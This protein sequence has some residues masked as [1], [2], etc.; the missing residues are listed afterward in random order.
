MAKVTFFGGA[1]EVTGSCFLFQSPRFIDSRSGESFPFDPK[2]I[3][4]LFVTHAHIDHTGRI[5]KL[6]KDGFKGKIYSTEP[7]KEFRAYL[8]VGHGRNRVAR[9]EDCFLRRS[10]KSA[11][12]IVKKPR[13]SNRRRF[14]DYRINVWKQRSRRQGGPQNQI[15]AGNRRYASFR[16]SIDDSGF[17]ARKNPGNSF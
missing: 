5:P 7:T 6:V 13:G 8:G 9:Q 2:G 14:F 17:F 4:T 11:D 1:Q 12:T 3:S 10:W 15:R 16:R